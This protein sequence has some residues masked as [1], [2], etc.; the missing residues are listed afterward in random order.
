[1]KKTALF[2]SII[3]ALSAFFIPDVKVQAASAPY[4]TSQT[5]VVI[6]ADTGTVLYDKNMNRQMHPASITKIMTAMLALENCDTDDVM[7]TSHNAVYS[8]PYN[9][10]HIALF[11]NE[12]ITVEQALYALGIE[13]ANDAANV[14]AEHISGTNGEFGKLMTERARQ[15]GT[16]NTN[17]TNPHGLP[18]DNHYTTAYDMAL[19]TAEAIEIDGFADYFST[20]RFDMG[21]T[22]EREETRQ[23]WNAN[24]F[25]NGY[26]PCDGLIMSKT[27]WTEEARHTLVTAA[28]RDGVTLICVV[29][30]SEKQGDKYDDTL[31][32]LDWGFANFTTARVTKED[33]VSSMPEKINFWD[34]STAAVEKDSYMV[35][36]FS[37]VLPKGQSAKDLD[38]EW[39]TAALDS[40]NTMATITAE[41][42]YTLDGERY[43][44][45][46]QE[47]SVIVNSDKIKADRSKTV[48]AVK[49]V[50][51]TVFNVLLWGLVA[52]FAFVALRQLI[53]IEDRRRKR[54][55]RK[56][57]MAKRRREH[58]TSDRY[59]GDRYTGEGKSEVKK[60]IYKDSRN[61]SAD[62]CSGSNSG[63]YGQ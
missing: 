60:V 62:S 11:E 14:I 33:M 31:A 54:K 37:V 39:S 12:Q 32:L 47:I 61:G 8:L 38:F 6:E 56:E 9:T 36:N 20:N 29:M 4:I 19:I 40:N 41:A 50:G 42:Y 2:L 63:R 44:C 18:E 1:M 51:L 21:P 30:Y 35:Q 46:E 43:L 13:S 59:T 52:Y 57:V 28:E 15:A 45:G 3:L 26:E 53:I 24:Y 22:N 10:S 55:R 23:F 25:I 17:F 58:R 16:K 49:R 34:G 48:N 5:A 27:G 7:T